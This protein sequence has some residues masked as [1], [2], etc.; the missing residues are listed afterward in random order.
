MK[1]TFNNILSSF[2]L[3]CSIY[4]LIDFLSSAK[5]NQDLKIDQAELNNIKYGIF[6]IDV[7]KDNFAVII[8]DKIKEFEL[9]AENKKIFKEKIET[10]LY[11]IIDKIDHSIREKNSASIFGL[12]KQVFTDIFLDINLL[13][14]EV[15]DLAE[16]IINELDDDRFKNNIKASILEQLDKYVASTVSETDMRLFNNI[17]L[18]YNANNKEVCLNYL[19]EAITINNKAILLDVI[20]IL[21]FALIIFILLIPILASNTGFEMLILIMTS[22][23][24]LIGGVITPMIEIEAKITDLSFT[25]IGTEISFTDQIIYFQSKSILDVVVILMNER[26]VLMIITGALI[27]SFSILFPVL[28]LS[29]LCVYFKNFKNLR[30]HRLIKFFALRSGKWSMADVFVVAIFMAYIGFNGI[31]NNQMLQ[32]NRSNETYEVLTTNGT[33]LQFGFYLFL[34]FCIS[35]LFIAHRIDK[36]IRV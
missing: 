13:R 14:D 23:V 7:W 15:P 5:K 8:S 9:K 3:L 12:F 31:V 21:S 36:K 20:F 18:K 32:L 22:L 30:K 11:Q 25:L 16:I 6:N 24:L 28:K 1:F 33:N 26:D 35:G 34:L 2:L 17:L 10:I 19:D 4:F 29:S 27:F